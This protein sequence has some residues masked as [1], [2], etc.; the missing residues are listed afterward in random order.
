MVTSDQIR[1][2]REQTDVSIMACKR[3]LEAANGDMTRAIELLKEEGARI[4]SKKAERSTAIGIVEAYVH[5]NQ[6][7]GVLLELRSE[8]DFVARNPDFKSLA[9]EVAMHIAAASPETVEDL[10]GQ[11]FI[12]DERKTVGTLVQEAIARFGENITIARFSRFQI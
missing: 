9:H 2:L 12:K 4:A 7:I 10:V 11:P 8:T 6:K 5:G 1:E 3:A